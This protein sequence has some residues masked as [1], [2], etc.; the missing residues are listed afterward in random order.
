MEYHRYFGQFR[1]KPAK[2]SIFNWTKGS[3][4]ERLGDADNVVLILECWMLSDIESEPTALLTV[5]KN[6]TE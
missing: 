1:T 5:L 2:W 3:D 6:S 4:R